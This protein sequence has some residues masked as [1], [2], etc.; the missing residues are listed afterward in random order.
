MW[1]MAKEDAGGPKRAKKGPVTLPR[2]QE[3]FNINLILIRGMR[4]IYICAKQ[5]LTT[6]CFK[7]VSTLENKADRTI[8][9]E[10]KSN[11]P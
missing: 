9:T 6:R 1:H 3:R 4:I 7:P 8:A 2:L 5:Q 10:A 11:E